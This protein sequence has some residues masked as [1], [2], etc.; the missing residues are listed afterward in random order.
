MMIILYITAKA[1]VS[2]FTYYTNLFVRSPLYEITSNHR[3]ESDRL[4]GWK[5][6]KISLKSV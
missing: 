6:I 3:L 1:K 5:L 4:Y 2:T